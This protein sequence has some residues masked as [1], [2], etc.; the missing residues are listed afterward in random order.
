MS[1]G[2][3]ALSPGAAA[4]ARAWLGL[5]PEFSGDVEALIAQGCGWGAIKRLLHGTKEREMTLKISAKNFRGLKSA[6][7]SGGPLFL[8][9]A[10]NAQG[11]SSLAQAIAACLT[12]RAI[13][14]SFELRKQDIRALVRDGTS[15]ATVDIVTDRGTA[16]MVYPDAKLSTTGDAPRATMFAAGLASIPTMPAKERAAALAP[17]M[18]AMPDL[19]DLKAVLIEE[20]PED[21]IGQCWNAIKRD[22]WD[23]VLKSVEERR[24]RSRATWEQIAGESFGSAKA[25]TWRPEGWADDLF[26]GVTI[27]QLTAAK[28]K[29]QTAVDQ[30]VGEAAVEV[31][32]L[33]KLREVA[34]DGGLRLQQL[35]EARN[36]VEALKR[37]KTSVEELRFKTP[38]PHNHPA[39]ECPHCGGKIRLA[40]VPN[41][42]YGEKLE[43]AVEIGEEENKKR[44]MTMAELD[45]RL[46]NVVGRIGAAERALAIAEERYAESE[47]ARQRI[48]AGVA[49]MGAD[50][51][52]REF[53][54]RTDLHNAETDLIRLK[55]KTEAEEAYQRWE[56][57]EKF[58]VVLSAGP[59]GL[60]AKKLAEATLVWNSH[61]LAPLCK[62]AGWGAVEITEDFRV[63]L[64]GRIFTLLSD[65]DQMR[66]KIVLQVAMA[67]IDESDMVIIDRAEALDA[68]NK[69]KLMGL[70][71]D[72]KI[73]ALVCMVVPNPAAVPDLAKAG[74]GSTIWIKDGT[75]VPLSE[76]A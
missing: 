3:P 16:K 27:E 73:P 17:Y 18:K 42:P 45:G 20:F 54:A 53:K 37:E 11:K 25:R 23:A 38:P 28:D 13:E 69:K 39:L 48:E 62:T 14:D 76:A 8:I 15:L 58:A 6:E 49:V 19:D 44:R 32:D 46:S 34:T 35:D 57:N 63:T 67:K 24:A 26:D 47:K 61:I 65:S 56:A 1:Y 43:K 22:G 9:A 33:D 2:Y 68:A 5:S 60:R 51:S 64:D 41:R 30:A 52:A 50:E 31:A 12:G 7:L 36:A 55:R 71:I 10:Q 59:Q 75:A 4:V 21:I 40:S 66:V 72:Q 70:L 29:A 74:V